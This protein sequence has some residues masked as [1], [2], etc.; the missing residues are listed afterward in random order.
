MTEP[1]P[2]P[3]KLNLFLHV[4]G[5]RPDGYHELQTAFQFVDLC[6]ELRFEPRDDGRIVRIAGAV[7]VPAHAD[8]VVRA[9]EAL[10]RATGTRFGVSI[11]VEKRIPIGGG[12][13]GGSSDAATTL[14]ALNRIWQT[15]LTTAELAALGL[16]LG[17]DV[18]VFVHGKAAFAAGV[19]ERLTPIEPPQSD[20][21]IVDPGVEVATAAVF[22]APELTRNSAPITIRALFEGGGRNDCEAVVRSRYP[23]VA[24]ALDWLGQFGRARMT[25]TGACVFVA[26]EAHARAEDICS[27]VPPG[28]RGFACRGLNRSPLNE[29]AAQF[30]AGAGI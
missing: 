23:A 8:L 26:V 20:F 3:A 29:R 21:A 27:K 18:P 6:D 25:G 30:S 5:R 2:A 16:A 10:R 7:E 19:G 24:Q 28:W 15:D 22:Q 9:A 14:V 1:W 11:A 17:A 13:G 4:L 12:L